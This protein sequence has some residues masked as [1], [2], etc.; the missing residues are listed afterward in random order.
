MK[1]RE[2]WYH[3]VFGQ[4]G[5]RYLSYDYTKGTKQE[6]AFL[7]EL[8]GDDLNQRIID[9]GCGP[10]RHVNELLKYGYH[11]Y[12]LDLSK[13]FLQIAKSNSESLKNTNP[14]VCADARNMPFENK[15]DWGVC[16]CEGAFGIMENDLQNQKVIYS[17]SQLLKPGG[18]LL[19]NV[20]NASFI[21]RHPQNDDYVDVKNCQGHWTEYY[22]AE[23]GQ[24]NEENCSNRYY[25]YPEMKIRLKIAGLTPLNVWGTIAGNYSKKE[26]ELDDFEMLILAKKNCSANSDY[27]SKYL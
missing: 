15:F 14:F 25:T 20:L 7:A 22:T 11:V 27:C 26:L 1:L 24:N 13:R 10:G 18:K 4:I 23:N 9:I 17:I 12:G 5:E 21:F 8:F 3:K 16:L 6:A 19:L 2:Q